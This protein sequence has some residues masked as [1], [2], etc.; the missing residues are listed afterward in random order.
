M[1]VSLDWDSGFF[2][3]RVG[4]IDLAQDS[5]SDLDFAIRNAKQE[6]FRLVYIFHDCTDGAV[7]SEGCEM[8]RSIGD[9]VDVR[10][11]Y[12]L[13]LGPDSD[14]SG[15]RINRA[16]GHFT[17]KERETG[18]A[19]SQIQALALLAGSNSRFFLDKR[20]CHQKA[21]ELYLRWIEKCT[22][23]VL[24][25]CVLEAFGPNGELAGF[26]TIQISNCVGSIGLFA[27]AP[28][29]QG[30]GVG[31]FLLQESHERMKR[32]GVGKVT[33]VTQ[34]RNQAACRAYE[35][36]GYKLVRREKVYHVWL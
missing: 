5:S 24:A 36:N 31:T 2:G 20:I 19:D 28:K 29:F 32:R 13:S 18:G 34:G 9:L 35:R 33:V 7:K 17:I 3:F 11:T 8:E 22:R 27:V 23:R 4:R 16:G 6:D 14:Y 15:L 10:Q 25:D 12:C 26:I 21:E 1:L 30:V